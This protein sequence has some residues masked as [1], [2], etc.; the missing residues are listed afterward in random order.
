MCATP[1]SDLTEKNLMSS[2]SERKSRIRQWGKKCMQI[3]KRKIKV[4]FLQICKL[5]KALKYNSR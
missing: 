2:E 3:Q 1:T 5:Y 4:P